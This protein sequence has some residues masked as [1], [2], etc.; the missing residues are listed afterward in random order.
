MVVMYTQM[1][2]KNRGFFSHGLDVHV[3]VGCRSLKLYICCFSDGFAFSQDETGSMRQSQIVR[4][5]DTRE[6]KPTGE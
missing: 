2:V 4:L 1:A 3:H 5:V 6:T